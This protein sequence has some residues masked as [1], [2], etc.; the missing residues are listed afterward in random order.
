MEQDHGTYDEAARLRKENDFLAAAVAAMEAR[1]PSAE[2]VAWLHNKRVES[3]RALWAW[4]QI[5]RYA[6]G[7]GIVASLIGAALTYLAN[8]VI[9]I[10]HKP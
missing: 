8:N 3:E 7:V 2:D 10:G 1:L 9:T 6:P 4:Q 5:K